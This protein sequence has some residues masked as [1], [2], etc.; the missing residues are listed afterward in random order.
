MVSF[1]YKTCGCHIMRTDNMKDLG[2]FLIQNFIS[3]S[4]WTLYLHELHSCWVTCHNL[5]L[6]NCDSL[7]THITLVRSRHEYASIAWNMLTS[8]NVNNFVHIQRKFLVLCH[9]RS[10]PQ[11]NYSYVSAFFFFSSATFHCGLQYNLPPF[12]TI[13]ARRMPIFYSHYIQVLFNLVL[14]S[15]AFIFPG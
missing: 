1:Q 11:I 12:P 14:P 6:F 8:S 10:F 5:F 13:P 15:F 3:I 9:S 7:L 4:T 2:V